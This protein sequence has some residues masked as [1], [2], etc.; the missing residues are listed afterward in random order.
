MNNRREDIVFIINPSLWDN[1]MYPCGI[2]CL[3]GY[4]EKNGFDN[5]ILD[6]KI[7]SR[8]VKNPLSEK[9]IVDKIKEIKPKIVCFSASHREFDEVVRIN[10]ALK[11]LDAGIFTL[12][13][14]PQPTFRAQDFLDNGFDF[15]CI[16]EGE[17]TLYNFVQEVFNQSYQWDKIKGLAWRSQA[18]NIYNQQRE[19][20][21]VEDI[22][23]VS[24]LPYEKIDQRYFDINIGTIRGLPLR[25]ALLL[26][27][28]GCPFSC[29]YCGCNLIFGRKLRFRSFKNIEQ[30]IKY[31]KEHYDIE[32][33]WIVDDT[34]TIKKE[35]AQ[36]VSR[37][38]KKYDIIWG[39]QSRVDT[40]DEEL[41]K[42]MKEAGCVQIDFGVESGSQKILDEVVDKKTNIMQIRRAFA[43]SKKYRIRRLANFMIGFPGETSE[44]FRK[45]EEIADLIDADVYIFAIA[46]PLP[47][48][49][50]YD[51][52]N[53]KINPDEYA[54]LDWNGSAITERLNKSEIKN[55]VAQRI[56]LHK[57]Y[58]FRYI[59]KSILAVDNYLFFLKE[60]YK[61][62][63]LVFVFKFLAAH[64][65]DF[66]K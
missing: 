58:L 27:S 28:R 3:S 25:G 17:V 6:S 41:I 59:T 22:N 1:N 13:G 57:K 37:I 35:H 8:K 10:N 55:L 60:K 36:G 4:L 9:I 53:E 20:M 47:G 34:F 24:R 45:T 12:I 26:T 21:T 32:G 40:V 49:R 42:I 15:V 7:S 29:S 18:A 5:I 46:T 14:G 61:L 43:L 11:Q 48:T 64:L 44:D 31:L 2:L 63:R 38:L 66:K 33:I 19:L 54:L 39:C 51:L 56:R 50:L 65:R 52:V 62:Q 23:S 16:G 30:E